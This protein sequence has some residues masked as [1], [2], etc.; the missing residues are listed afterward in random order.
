MVSIIIPCYNTEAYI[1]ECISSLV[2]QTHNDIEI[3][4]VDDGSTDSTGSKLDQWCERDSR[5]TVFHTENRGRSAARNLGIEKSS[6]EY[7]SFIDSDDSVTSEY[8]E[9]MLNAINKYD[10]DI[11]AVSQYCNRLTT[12]ELVYHPA[13]SQ[14]A[15]Y[16]D[17]SQY[18]ADTYLDKGKKFF[19]NNIL[20]TSKL[21]KRFLFDKVKFPV[22]RIIEDCWIFPEIVIQCKRIVVLPDCL[23]FYRQR[24]DNTTRILSTR[25]VDSKCEAWLHNKDWWQTTNDELVAYSEKYLCHFL[26]KNASLVSPEKRS[27]F[28]AEYSSMVKHIV[29]SKH[30]SAKTKFKYLTFASPILVWK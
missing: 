21:Y 14:P 25:L 10:A 3:I 20:A 9:I 6:G 12:G 2:N 4:V 16:D 26:Y 22:G 27:Y 24:A 13:V 15:V 11:V 23:Y 8:V 29:F 7:I 18:V 28:K 5:I 1:D 17:Y 30:L 19:Q